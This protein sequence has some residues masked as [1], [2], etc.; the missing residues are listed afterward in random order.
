[1]LEPWS[2]FH[3]PV[4]LLSTLGVFICLITS[5]I[6]KEEYSLSALCKKRSLLH[7]IDEESEAQRS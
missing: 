7:S 6:Q 4:T 1:M 2:T 5:T 3:V